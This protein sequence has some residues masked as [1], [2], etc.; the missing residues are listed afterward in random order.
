MAR[1]Y[2]GTIINRW[3]LIQN[4]DNEMWVC[5]CSCGKI[6]NVIVRNVIRGFSKSCGCLNKE[7]NT[8]RSLLAYSHTPLWNRWVAMRQR[9]NDEN[10][11]NYERYGGRGI[12]VCD[13]W[14][15]SYLSFKDWAIKNGFS[16]TLE[17]DRID[18]NG[19]YSPNNCRFATTK[20]NANNRRS[21]VFLTIG[22]ETHNIKW[23]SEEAGINYGTIQSR[24]RYGW[25]DEDL[26][27]PVDRRRRNG[28]AL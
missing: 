2:A 4:I 18:N 1:L 5:R 24:R 12:K 10:C 11:S 28:N 25:C 8:Q 7:V 23:W 17:I 19:N 13:E 21:N 3:T 16:E 26:T 27:K 6:K 15:K 14:D 20:E 22:S 9:C